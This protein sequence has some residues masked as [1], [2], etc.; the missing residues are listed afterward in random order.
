MKGEIARKY[1][2]E[3]GRKATAIG[4]FKDLKFK[5]YQ[6]GSASSE[7]L[8]GIQGMPKYLTEFT[9]SRKARSDYWE[10]L[11]LM[12]DYERKVKPQVQMDKIAVLKSHSREFEQHLRSSGCNDVDECS[13]STSTSILIPLRAT[14]TNKKRKIQ[15]EEPY[16]WLQDAALNLHRGGLMNLMEKDI[17]N[18]TSTRRGLYNLALDSLILFQ[19]DRKELSCEKDAL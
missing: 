10:N 19:H 11:R 2:E 5:S 1:I 7:Y 14:V 17:S 6:H 15:L 3:N 9:G 4:F 18:L 8:A 16:K 12:E 13:A